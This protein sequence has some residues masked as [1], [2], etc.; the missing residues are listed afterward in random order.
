MHHR[1]KNNFAVVFSLLGLQSRDIHDT[2]VKAMFMQSRDRINSIALLHQRLYQSQD[3]THVNFSEYISTLAA[4]LF[5]AY[6][7]DPGRISTVIEIDDIVLDVDKVLPCG[8]IVNELISNALKYGFPESHKEKGQIIVSLHKIN[9]NE[10]ELAVMD[11]GVGLPGDFDIE[12][13]QS[14]GL[15]LVVMLAEGQLEGKL[16]VN[17][18]GGAKFQIQFALNPPEVL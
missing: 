5:K 12:K 17:G 11:N 2:E 9:E 3:L 15:K 18:K 14:L 4:D 10:V 7:I 16:K 1:V 13:N 8:L 6:E